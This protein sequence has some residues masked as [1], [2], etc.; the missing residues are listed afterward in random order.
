M[1]RKTASGVSGEHFLSFRKVEGE[2]KGWGAGA[3]RVRPRFV[4]LLAT[5][6]A[7]KS[8]MDIDKGGRV[9]AYVHAQLAFVP[10]YGVDLLEPGDFLPEVFGP[11]TPVLTARNPL[12][13]IQRELS[14]PMLAPVHP[15]WLKED[16]IQADPPLAEK[17]SENKKKRKQSLRLRRGARSMGDP[18]PT[19]EPAEDHIPMK[20]ERRSR[21]E[22]RRLPTSLSFFHGFA[23]KNVGPSRLTVNYFR[24][25][26]GTLG[27]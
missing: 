1:D 21:R 5:S 2:D 17:S 12:A 11:Q 22:K 23:P 19:S 13:T 20:G 16:P 10:F 9:R 4:P 25:P 24:Y 7:W 15:E 27:R 3:A 14:P 8:R 18:D 6:H 26:F